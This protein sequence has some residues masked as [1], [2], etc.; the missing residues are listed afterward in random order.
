M[1]GSGGGNSDH[2][3]RETPRRPEQTTGG[4][5][6]PSG[7]PGDC[8]ITEDTIL[9]SV[10]RTVLATLRVGDLLDVVFEPGP[11]QRL[12]ARTSGGATAGSIT[13]PSMLR[14]I[15]CIRTGVQYVAEVTAIRGAQCH[16]R[17]RPR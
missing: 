13:S 15:Q 16:V 1:S 10:D 5:G 3:W 8:D 12:I 2:D 7:V 11:P 4:G 17:I 14:L 9:N 6:P